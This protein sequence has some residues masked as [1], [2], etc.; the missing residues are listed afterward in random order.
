MFVTT[1]CCAAVTEVRPVSFAAIRSTKDARPSRALSI[2]T[3]SAVVVA[4][5]AYAGWSLL[6]GS[7]VDAEPADEGIVLGAG[8]SPT[9]APTPEEPPRARLY[10]DDGTEPSYLPVVNAHLEVSDDAGEVAPAMEQL[11]FTAGTADSRPAGAVG[12]WL[13]G[14]IED[15][16]KAASARRAVR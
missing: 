5:L 8:A 1:R 6:A 2:A 15:T 12:A 3:G 4:C 11:G 10:L 16:P 13:T 14:R 7:A 9:L